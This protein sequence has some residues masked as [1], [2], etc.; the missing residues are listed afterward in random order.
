MRSFVRSAELA[1]SAKLKS[2]QVHANRLMGAI[3]LIYVLGTKYSVIPFIYSS[4][5]SSK[6]AKLMRVCVSLGD[7]LSSL[8]ESYKLSSAQYFCVCPSAQEI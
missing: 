5:D 6:I 3:K 8:I 4:A 2:Q 1:R 7:R